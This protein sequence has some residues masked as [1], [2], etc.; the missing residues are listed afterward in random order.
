MFE[1]NFKNVFFN[2]FMIYFLAKEAEL[3]QIIGI[4]LDFD[5]LNKELKN[6]I[7]QECYDFMLKNEI[8]SMD[9][10]GKTIINDSYKKYITMFENPQYCCIVQEI[11]NEK[12]CSYQRK[13]YKDHDLYIGLDYETESDSALYEFNDHRDAGQ[14]AF[15]NLDIRSVLTGNDDL[16][17]IPF[18]FSEDEISKARQCVIVT[19]Y[20]PKEETYETIQSIYIRKDDWYEIIT[21]D[22][23]NTSLS[24]VL[25]PV[26][27]SY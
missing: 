24:K 20:I 4:G 23:N 16:A 6:E 2:D 7:K 8:I 9:F 26:S 17:A 27:L 3:R 10:S 22:A 25:Y 12:N 15:L 19:E 1:E 5:T 21:D 18:A 11:D 14:F 13:I